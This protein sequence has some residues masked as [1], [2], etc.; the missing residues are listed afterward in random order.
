MSNT[1][2]HFVISSKFDRLYHRERTIFLYGNIMTVD[3][4]LSIEFFEEKARRLGGLDSFLRNFIYNDV[5]IISFKQKYVLLI[6]FLTVFQ[7][8]K[9]KSKQY[10]G[11]SFD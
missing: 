1:D 7:C 8:N 4:L 9:D 10:F 11:S 2:V 6:L 5:K 3:V